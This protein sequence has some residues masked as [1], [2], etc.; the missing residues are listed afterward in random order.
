MKS[1]TGLGKMAYEI[2]NNVQNEEFTK[3]QMENAIRTAVADAC[4]GEWNYYSFMENRYKV[5]AIMAEIMPI[6]TNASLA[7]RFGSFAQ[8]KDTAMGDLNYFEVE[9][10]TLYP[11]CTSARGNQDIERQ[12]IIDKNFSVPTQMKTIKLYDEFDRF[13]AGKIDLARLSTKVTNSYEAHVGQLIANTIYGS[14]SAVGS[15]YKTSGAFAELALDLIIEHVKAS[16][17]TTDV[18]IWG[19]MSALGKVVVAQGY[20]DRNKDVYNSLGYYGE[21]KGSSLFAMPQAY[22][23]GTQTFGVERDYIIIV[24]ASEPIVKVMFEG[25][26]VVNMTDGMGRNDMQPEFLYGRR[27]GASALT[28]AD[29]RYGFYKFTS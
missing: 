24:P 4:G 28:T 15:N 14:Y 12:K 13:M 1:F 2:T 16:T 27:V 9:D 26:A 29:G 5:F 7:N 22:V 8:F 10:N 18:Q 11:V 20:S 19:S 21:Y 3:P 25:D 17:G 6:T 23:A